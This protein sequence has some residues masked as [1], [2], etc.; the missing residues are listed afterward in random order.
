[1]GRIDKRTAALPGTADPISLERQLIADNGQVL[2][3]CLS[4]QHPI[5]WIS[6]GPRKK[7]CSHAVLRAHRKTLKSR[8]HQIFLEV[9]SDIGR[10]WEPSVPAGRALGMLALSMPA[11][12]TGV[13]KPFQ[14][15]RLR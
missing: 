13:T 14:L 4:D 12:R 9:P 11:G 1:M 15:R 6:L 3:L 10:G 7:A 2:C 8:L 5:K